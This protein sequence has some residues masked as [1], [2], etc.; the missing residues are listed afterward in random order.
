MPKGYRLREKINEGTFGEIYAATNSADQI[1]AIKIMKNLFIGDIPTRER[2]A[3]EVSL[4]Q[5]LRHDNIIPVLD[6]GFEGEETYLVMP[7][8]EGE[9]LLELMAHKP[10]S[11]LDAAEF[12]DH[13]CAALAYGHQHGVIHRDIKPENVLV[14]I[15]PL[16]YYLADFG[17]A[18]RYGIDRDLTTEGT[19]P[20]SPSYIS[21]ELIMAAEVDARADLYSLGVITF[22]LLLGVLPF[23]MKSDVDTIKA[24]VYAPPPSPRLIR[25]DFPLALETFLIKALA[26]KKEERYLS[27]TEFVD[28]FR[29][30]LATMPPDEQS[31]VYWTVQ[32]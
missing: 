19:K 27:A 9:T 5:L 25:A 22:E 6:F 20:G 23:K 30:A 12:L 1:V 3:R 11:P 17:L 2:F 13:I 15:N 26:K 18:K 8:I 7:L 4:L 29:E 28:H 32:S 16:H 21:P 14:E 24:H 10:F 31:K